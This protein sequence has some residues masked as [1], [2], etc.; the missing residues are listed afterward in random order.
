MWTKCDNNKSL[1]A[2]SLTVQTNR[3]WRCGVSGLT[4]GSNKAWHLRKKN[5][6]LVLVQKS[7]QNK[8]EVMTSRCKKMQKG[9]HRKPSATGQ[10][11]LPG[12]YL[13]RWPHR[14]FSGRSA[15]HR[16]C[17]HSVAWGWCSSDSSSA[18]HAHT[19]HCRTTR[20][21][22]WTSHRW[23]SD[24]CQGRRGGYGGVR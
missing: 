4:A 11:G 18:S 21:S 7:S 9:S 13:D 6:L 22:T 5:R 19:R 17:L 23:L 1:L 12:S 16:M 15:P 20:W 2:W 3:L 14:H 8:D 24:Q 10:T